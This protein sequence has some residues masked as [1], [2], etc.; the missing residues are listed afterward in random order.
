MILVMKYLILLTN[1]LACIFL[2]FVILVDPICTGVVNVLRFKC[3]L[4][5]G[6]PTTNS[7]TYQTLQKMYHTKK[8]KKGHYFIYCSHL[9]G[10]GAIGLN[11]VVTAKLPKN[12]R[13][14]V[15]VSITGTCPLLFH[16]FIVEMSYSKGI[17]HYN[18]K[19]FGKARNPSI[20]A[21]NHD[22]W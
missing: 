10:Y 8:E 18:W 16:A 9:V 6:K 20:H 13:R 5:W 19:T 7:S 2:V 4:E 11:H 12:V 21:T 3:P 14:I 1:K 22:P 15:S 17:F